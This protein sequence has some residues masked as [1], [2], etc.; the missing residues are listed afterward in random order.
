MGLI[1]GET[2]HFCSCTASNFRP[3]RDLRRTDEG[4]A[5]GETCWQTKVSPWVT[6]AGREGTGIWD[7]LDVLVTR[8]SD[9]SGGSE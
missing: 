1:Y 3:E 7:S 2:S 8:V 9:D 5:L 4:L 6:L